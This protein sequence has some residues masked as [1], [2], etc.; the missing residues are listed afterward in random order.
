MSRVV[1]IYGLK[2]PRT[3]LVHYVGRTVMP[4]IRLKAH[5][6]SAHSRRL[7]EWCADLAALGIE[8]EIAI[9]D[10]T[11]IVGAIDCEGKWIAHHLRLNPALLNATSSGAG[12]AGSEFD[13]EW[14]MLLV[15]FR[16][17]EYECLREEA[18]RTRTPMSELVRRIVA[19]AHS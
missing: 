3:D 12:R 17:D 16:P 18:H 9:F 10:Q 7:R 13:G 14:Q 1:Y 15:R 19:E 4:S 11:D 5:L 2:D 6:R 8:P